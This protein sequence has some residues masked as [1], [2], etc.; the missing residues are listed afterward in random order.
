MS[1]VNPF[2]NSYT[3]DFVPMVL[4]CA[5]LIVVFECVFKAVVEEMNRL[6]MIV[7]ISHTSW[8]TASAALDHSKAP[9]IFS[10]SSSYSICNHSRN[11]PDWLLHKLVRKPICR[12]I[13]CPLSCLIKWL[14]YQSSHW[15]I[16]FNYNFFIYT[17]DKEHAVCSVCWTHFGEGTLSRTVSFITF[18]KKSIWL[19]FLLFGLCLQL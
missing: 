8:D 2:N 13:N 9:V 11:V 15:L 17:T 5:W 14:S 18:S 4:Y 1:C 10:H 3:C 12:V 6:G 7:D 16:Y 19:H